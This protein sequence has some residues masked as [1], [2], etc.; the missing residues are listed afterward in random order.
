MTVNMIEFT[1]ELDCEPGIARPN[2]YIKDV[3]E[4]C[5]L[6]L[7]EPDGKFFGNWTWVYNVE[8]EHYDRIKPLLEE[9]ISQ[10]YHKGAIRYGSW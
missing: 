9:R 10:L 5:E 3:I 7:K 2:L 1:I 8:Q 6:E 4:G